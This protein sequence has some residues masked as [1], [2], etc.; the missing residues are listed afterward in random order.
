MRPVGSN[1]AEGYQVI[2]PPVVLQEVKR[3]RSSL[4]EAAEVQRFAAAL[5]TINSRL[6]K[7]PLVF[8]EPRNHLDNLRLAI[9]VASVR[10]LYV[11]YAVHDERPLVF[12]RFFRLLGR[13]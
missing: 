2:Y 4:T 9:R 1:G 3:L 8:G 13:P 10:P 6:R 12:V 5:R 7:D 11:S